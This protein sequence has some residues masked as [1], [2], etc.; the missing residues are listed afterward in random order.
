MLELT[1]RQR[2][3]LRWMTGYIQANRRPPTVAEVG[4]QFG[5]SG[6]SAFGIM[7]SL[8]KKGYLEKGD[9][10]SRSVRPVDLAEVSGACVDPVLR[11]HVRVSTSIGEV[12]GFSGSIHVGLQLGR[13][14]PL[15]IVKVRGNSMIG[16]G[17]RGGDMVVVRVQDKVEDNDVVVVSVGSEALI[18]R[19][20]LDDDG[21]ALLE[22][23]TRNVE[24]MKV[25]AGE[26]HVHGKVVAVYRELE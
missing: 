24:V 1:E 9:G 7:R 15:F 20:S 3:V 21:S 10:S 17:I 4:A 5:I 14:K 19:I 18:R 6:P 22:A 16:L 26:W 13:C 25:V 2:E 8:V 23:D 12:A 11:D